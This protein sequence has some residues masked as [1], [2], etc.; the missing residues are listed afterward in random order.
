M[1]MIRPEVDLATA[2]AF[3]EDRS[4]DAVSGVRALDVGQLS[5]VFAFSMAGRDS[6]LRF[7]LAREGFEHDRRAGEAFASATLPI[8]PVHEVGQVDAIFFAK[9][10][11]PDAYASTRDA[12]LALP[13]P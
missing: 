1:A 11:Q 3:L 5:R 10:N 4:G 7:A 6:I 8:P 9:T 2:R 13:A 12:L